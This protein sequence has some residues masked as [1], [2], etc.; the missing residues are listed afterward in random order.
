MSVNY[1]QSVHKM[2]VVNIRSATTSFLIY[3]SPLKHTIL[4]K[5]L[6]NP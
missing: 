1:E 6:S 5:I 4:T 2:F 3:Y